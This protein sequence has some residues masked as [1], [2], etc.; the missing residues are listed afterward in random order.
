MTAETLSIFSAIEKAQLASSNA[1]IVL[2]EIQLMDTPTQSIVETVFVANNN[3][4]L[5]YRNETYVAF[6][7]NITLRQEAGALPEITLTAM[8]LNRVLLDKLQLYGGASGSVVIIRIVNSGNLSGAPDYEETFE[9]TETSANS[10]SISA[11]L[12][13]DTALSKMFPRRTQLRD[14][15]PWRYKSVECSYTGPLPTC[16]LSLQGPNGCAAHNNTP[17]FGGRP[18]VRNR[19]IRFGN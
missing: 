7:F 9:V 13:I 17:N 3:E 2:A 16:T 4:P 5:V 14:R 19:A 8:D 6:P 15:C 10:Y 1:Y 18:A 11:K 12:G